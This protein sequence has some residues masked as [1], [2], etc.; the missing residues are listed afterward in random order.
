VIPDDVPSETPVVVERTTVSRP[1][2]TG[3]GDVPPIP[4]RE[5]DIVLL[6][7][8]AGG[9]AAVSAV[10]GALPADFPVPVLI[11]QHLDPRHGSLMAEILRRRTPLRVEEAREGTRTQPSTVSIAPPDEHLLVGANGRL[12]LSY[13]DPVHFVRPSADLFFESGAESFPGR[14]VGGLGLGLFVVR[15][16]AEIQG[17]RAWVEDAPGGGAAFRVLLPDEPQTRD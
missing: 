14:T 4:D 9:L 8:S 17:G 7:G 10:L 3:G 11:V 2:P 13:S 16:F 12:C 6:A 15:K 1:D 5:Y